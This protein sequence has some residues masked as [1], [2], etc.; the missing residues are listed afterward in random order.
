VSALLMVLV[1]GSMFLQRTRFDPLAMARQV[2]AA[3][4][5]QSDI[6]ACCAEKP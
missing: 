4:A 1:G 2:E 3:S 5:P 6:P